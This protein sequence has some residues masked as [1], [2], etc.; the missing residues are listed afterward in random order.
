ME[1]IVE[2]MS[3]AAVEDVQERLGNLGYAIDAAERER[4]TFGPSTAKGVA[5]FRAAQGLPAGREVDLPCW[6][7]LVSEGYEL[8]DRTLYLR[9]PFFHG[10]DV[11]VLQQ[12]L[13]TLGFSCGDADGSFGAHTEAAVKRFQ[14]NVGLYPDG[15]CF[16]D[17]FQALWHLH[18]V[19][20]DERRVT[21]H[22]VGGIGFARAASVLED[23]RITLCA[24]DPIA[25]NVAARIWNLASATSEDSGLALVNSPDETPRDAT[26]VLVIAAGAPDVEGAQANVVMERGVDLGLRL[27]AAVGSLSASSLSTTP[28]RVRIQLP[29]DPTDLD[30]SFTINDAQLHAAILLDAICAAFAP[31]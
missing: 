13:N 18:H 30:G 21:L 28:P 22:P 9:L 29:A 3:G 2:G 26:C 8:G 10:H 24:C 19:W 16:Q 14:E 23:T 27:R 12:A 6:T 5:E 7:E 20:G 31:A 17:T 15:I 11:R 1:P 25:R 4:S